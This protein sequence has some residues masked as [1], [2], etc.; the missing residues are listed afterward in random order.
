M[1]GNER[2]VMPL[3]NIN[4]DLT[5]AAVIAVKVGITEEQEHWLSLD[6]IHCD[7][8]E[9]GNPILPGDG[10]SVVAH[11]G[12]IEDDGERSISEW[13]NLKR[14]LA[15]TLVAMN[16]VDTPGYDGSITADGTVKEGWEEEHDPFT[17]EVLAV[18][19]RIREVMSG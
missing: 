9:N 18:A 6:F 5:K 16:E 7:A 15:R 2:I 4:G 12:W 14:L 1:S 3:L 13:R 19:E 10:V 17:D 11:F 8:D